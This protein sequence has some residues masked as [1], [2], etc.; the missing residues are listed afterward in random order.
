MTLNWT[1]GGVFTS[2][3]VPYVANQTITAFAATVNAV[4]FGWTATPDPYYGDWPATELGYSASKGA[5]A[6]D[7]PSGAAIFHVLADSETNPRFDPDDG[8]RSGIAWVGRS[9]NG[10][11]AARWGPGGEQLFGIQGYRPGVVK[12]TYNGGFAVVP[13]EVQ[14]ACV[15]LVKSQLERLETPLILK[16]EAGGEYRYEINDRMVMALP[17]HV[18]QGLSRWRLTNA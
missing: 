5:A 2:Q 3:V 1:L 9:S 4:G 12:V 10:G 17:P 14:L 13:Q 7:R 16:S 18:L 8:Q 15:E 11:N 6:N